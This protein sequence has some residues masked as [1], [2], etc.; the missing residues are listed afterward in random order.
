VGDFRS[1]DIA[2]GG[3]GEPLVTIFDYDYFHNNNEDMI[4]LNIVEY[5]I[6]VFTKK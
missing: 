4:L 3:Q 2:L 1:G 5:R 6:Y